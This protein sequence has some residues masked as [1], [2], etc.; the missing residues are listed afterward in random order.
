MNQRTIN[1]IKG[2]VKSVKLLYSVQ[3]ETGKMSV[4]SEYFSVLSLVGFYRCFWLCI[5][6]GDNNHSGVR[7]LTY[8]AKAGLPELNTSAC[9]P[10]LT[11]SHLITPSS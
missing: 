1:T 9:F 10:Q 4:F 3:E 7:K 5:S 6:I 8:P 2:K 11:L